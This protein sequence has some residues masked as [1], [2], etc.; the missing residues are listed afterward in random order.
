MTFSIHRP[1]SFSSHWCKNWSD[2]LKKHILQKKQNVQQW[3]CGFLT[4]CRTLQILEERSFILI[5]QGFQLVYLARN[6]KSTYSCALKSKIKVEQNNRFVVQ[7]ERKLSYNGISFSSSLQTLKVF[8]QN[9]WKKMP[10]IPESEFRSLGLLYPLASN[11]ISIH[12]NLNYQS[13]GQAVMSIGI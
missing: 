2:D 4:S 3:I 7:M 13:F 1:S 11:L 9:K 8:H 12:F 5:I 6:F 10:S